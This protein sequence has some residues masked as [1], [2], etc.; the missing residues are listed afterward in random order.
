MKWAALLEFDVPVDLLEAMRVQKTACET[1][2]GASP[3][4]NLRIRH[5]LS[6]TNDSGTK[7]DLI[8]EFQVSL[9]SKDE[10]YVR[11]L[12]KQAQD[13]D[14]LLQNMTER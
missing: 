8:R 5:F 11:A 1:I 9:K 13:I 14:E 3:H 2:I 4:P 6:N 12:K 7:D 10:E